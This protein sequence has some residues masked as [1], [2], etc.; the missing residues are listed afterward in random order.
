MAE[1]W[2]KDARNE[3]KTDTRSEVEKEVGNL[4]EGQAKLSEQLKE[5]V[6]ARDSF[7]ASLKNA[8]K[9]AEEQ[10]KRFY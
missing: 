8:E 1:D 9:Q 6:R 3:A 4:K 10:R 7:E 5:I 2:V